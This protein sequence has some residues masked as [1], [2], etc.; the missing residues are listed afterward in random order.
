[1]DDENRLDDLNNLSE[2]DTK[3]ILDLVKNGK[4]GDCYQDKYLIRLCKLIRCEEGSRHGMI[5]PHIFSYSEQYKSRENYGSIIDIS[6]PPIKYG[7]VPI[8]IFT[9][10]DRP[11]S[12]SD[13]YIGTFSRQL[14]YPLLDAVNAIGARYNRISLLDVPMTVK[15]DMN[16]FIEILSHDKS[17]DRSSFKSLST[18]KDIGEH[19]LKYMHDKLLGP[20]DLFKVREKLYR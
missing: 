11:L 17:A 15:V 20:E 19:T 9:Y 8:D 5:M 7:Q 14:L 10:Y 1:M 4:F 3:I 6:R 18:R 2:S 16:S 12:S 13:L